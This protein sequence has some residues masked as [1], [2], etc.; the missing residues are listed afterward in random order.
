MNEYESGKGYSNFNYP[1][2]QSAVA[3]GSRPRPQSSN[4]LY[5][6]LDHFQPIVL[7]S[8]YDF[9]LRILFLVYHLTTSLI[10]PSKNSV[11]EPMYSP[12]FVLS[13]SI[14]FLENLT[15]CTRNFVGRFHIM[16]R[17]QIPGLRTRFLSILPRV[18][19]LVH[20]SSPLKTVL[21]CYFLCLLQKELLQLGWDTDGP[22][23]RAIFHSGRCQ[24]GTS[25]SVMKN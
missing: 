10:C 16:I 13:P 4:L 21:L 9:A 25:S 19:S 15:I 8:R 3:A 1:W 11:L 17:G 22:W 18:E 12:D 2:Q 20:S 14:S 7:P 6:A 23:D 5:R 24:S